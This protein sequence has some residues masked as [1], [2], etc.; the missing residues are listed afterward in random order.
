MSELSTHLSN[1][2][3]NRTRGK[4]MAALQYYYD[5]PTLG[6]AIWDTLYPDTE[7]YVPIP[8]YL[9]YVEKWNKQDF[10]DQFDISH[11]TF[12]NWVTRNVYR[13][14]MRWQFEEALDLVTNPEDQE[15]YEKALD[16]DAQYRPRGRSRDYPPSKAVQRWC[17]QQ[18][19]KHGEVRSVDYPT[20]RNSWRT[21][22]QIHHHALNKDWKVIAHGHYK[23]SGAKRFNLNTLDKIKGD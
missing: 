14:S 10:Q 9:H 15:L 18:M 3:L 22:Q 8:Q 23:R 6:V 12:Y 5:N 21:Q 1:L 11:V 2:K 4:K 7:P 17:S 16:S 19:R 20:S 13:E